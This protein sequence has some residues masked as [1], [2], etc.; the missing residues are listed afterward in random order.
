M[1][2]YY[3]FKDVDKTKRRNF[4]EEPDPGNGSNQQYKREKERMIEQ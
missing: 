1:E 4:R 2:T 3:I